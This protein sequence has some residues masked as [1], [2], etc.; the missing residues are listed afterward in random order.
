MS[1][2]ILFFISERGFFH[3]SF[4]SSIIKR[5]ARLSSYYYTFRTFSFHNTVV[6]GGW[7][8]CVIKTSLPRIVFS[9]GV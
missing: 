2:G 7:V 1:M 8:P 5:S 3:L 4:C 6:G 9:L